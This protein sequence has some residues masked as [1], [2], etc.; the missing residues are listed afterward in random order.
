V[1]RAQAAALQAS[2]VRQAGYVHRLAV[3]YEADA[4]R[5]RYLAGKV[6]TS[7]SSLRHLRSRSLAT[8]LV[9]RREAVLSY[10]GAAPTYAVPGESPAAVL[11][12]LEQ[13]AYASVALGDLAQTLA[14]FHNEQS[15]L[16]EVRAA[17]SLQLG[18]AVRTERAAAAARAAAL[19]QAA[20][21]Q[22]AL[23]RARSR[24]K[25]VTEASLAAAGPPVGDGIV[26]A[27][28]A[29]LGSFAAGRGVALG[30]GPSRGATATSAL[31]AGP[32]V[33]DATRHPGQPP[34]VTTRP[35]AGVAT[36]TAATAT[37]ATAT[38]L[39]DGPPPARPTASLDTTTLPGRSTT[40]AT[41][42]P[43]TT[44]TTT[45]TATTTTTTTTTAGPASTT[46]TTGPT[47]PGA[48]QPASTSGGAGA[49][50]HPPPAGGVWLELREC[51]S[52]DNYQADTGNGFYGAYQFALSTWANLGY[53]GRPD[54][55]PYWAQDQA[56]QKLQS[57][58][59]WSPW[60]ACSAALG[61]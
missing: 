48:G 33:G 4:A 2:E 12:D 49:G 3:A 27:L 22:A 45:T 24:L 15:Q 28:S 54:L 18:S 41:T 43:T 60:P 5:A 16:A 55:A 50:P 19:G 13:Q 56:A 35:D 39:R 51:E 25:S 37:A 17:Y 23:D 57:M 14:E 47:G 10:T 40:S 58:E 61:L 31:L 34:V 36:A 7:A 32:K 52:G 29:E 30:L 11:T 21:L 44:T 8:E 1:A 20:S 46:T 9:L 53:S 26:K 6:K 38:T 59:G 42:T